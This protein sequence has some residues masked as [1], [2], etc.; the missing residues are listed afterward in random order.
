MREQFGGYEKVGEITQK[1]EEV[2]YDTTFP[3]GYWW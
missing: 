3:S 2:V 1:Q